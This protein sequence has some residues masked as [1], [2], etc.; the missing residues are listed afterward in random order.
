MRHLPDTRLNERT[1]AMH[2]FSGGVAGCCE[3]LAC[4]PLDTIKVRLQL[5]GERLKRPSA[6]PVSNV[7]GLVMNTVAAKGTFL[8]STPKV[9]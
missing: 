6:L 2:L 1:W 9:V 4:H 8:N 5:R 7:G 3:A